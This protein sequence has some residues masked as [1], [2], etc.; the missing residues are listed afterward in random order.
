LTH[1]FKSTKLRKE[2]L[3]ELYRIA[4]KLE[5]EKGEKVGISDVV[6]LLLKKWKEESKL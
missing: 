2:T 4:G 3:A 6:D 1:E 5:Q